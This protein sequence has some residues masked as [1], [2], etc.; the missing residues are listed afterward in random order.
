MAGELR[1]SIA[2]VA[3]W[4]IPLGNSEGGE[5]I[6]ATEQLQNQIVVRGAGRGAGQCSRRKHGLR[7]TWPAWPGTGH[8][9]ARSAG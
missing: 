1:L 6:G 5:L 3:S 4:G 2:G 9:P 7:A 8:E